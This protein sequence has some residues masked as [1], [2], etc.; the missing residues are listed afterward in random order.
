MGNNETKL[1]EQKYR[2]KE[3]SIQAECLP[4]APRDRHTT[5]GLRVNPYSGL[6]PL[7]S[8]GE[9]LA[10]CSPTGEQDTTNTNNES[11]IAKTCYQDKLLPKCRELGIPIEQ[12]TIHY[13]LSNFVLLPRW[14]NNLGHMTYLMALMK[15]PD[16]TSTFALSLSAVSMGAFGNRPQSRSLRPRAFLKYMEAV[17]RVN[18]ALRDPELAKSDHTLAS[19]LLLGMFETIYSDKAITSWNNH[20]SGAVALLKMRGKEIPKNP[21][22]RQLYLI[23]RA[24]VIPYCFAQSKTLDLPLDW[25]MSLSVPGMHSSSDTNLKVV[26]LKSK[27]DLILTSRSRSLAKYEQVV[28]LA[29]QAEALEEEY[30]TWIA[31]LDAPWLFKTIVWNDRLPEEDED[32]MCFPGKVDLYG[33]MWMANIWNM[34]RACRLLLSQVHLRCVAWLY[35][36][37]DYK[38]SPEYHKARVHCEILIADIIASVPNFLGGVPEIDDDEGSTAGCAFPCGEGSRIVRKGVS[39]MFLL[40]PLSTAITSDFASVAQR[41]WMA[42]K[43]RSTSACPRGG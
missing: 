43:L 32:S 24:Q 39:G 13:F 8:S 26:D 5:T 16:S 31:G 15:T 3:V 28:Q 19:V 6:K 34:T 42:R 9:E 41:K 29:R 17:K 33:G 23:V 35:G 20:M 22:T 10:I 36:P 30:V 37:R 1:T 2:P 38:T 25:W 7:I 11:E 4:N 14:S 40:W 18:T 27:V 21:I 12:Q